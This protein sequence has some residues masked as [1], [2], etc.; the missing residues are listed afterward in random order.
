MSQPSPFYL[1]KFQWERK[2]KW[3]IRLIPVDSMCV[4]VLLSTVEKHIPN[5]RSWFYQNCGL[6]KILLWKLICNYLFAEKGMIIRKYLKVCKIFVWYQKKTMIK[7]HF[8]MES[9]FNIFWYYLIVIFA[10][11]KFKKY[12]KGRKT[13]LKRI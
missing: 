4:R 2:E 11:H 9:L 1:T 8:M 7:T 10:A 6:I 13:L 3:H 5:R 12:G